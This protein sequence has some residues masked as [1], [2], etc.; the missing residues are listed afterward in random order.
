MFLNDQTLKFIK[1]RDFYLLSKAKKAEDLV[2]YDFKK[3]A[4]SIGVSLDT[5]KEDA[6]AYGFDLR[7]H[8]P[9]L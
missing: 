5:V 2:D 4:D 9:V 6:K 8:K 1:Q 3:I 7:T